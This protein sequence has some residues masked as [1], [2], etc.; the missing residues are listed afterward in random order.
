M[1]VDELIQ[2]GEDTFRSFLDPLRSLVEGG[3]WLVVQHGV[4]DHKEDIVLI[5]RA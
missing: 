4:I 3:I 1:V 5:G 2:L